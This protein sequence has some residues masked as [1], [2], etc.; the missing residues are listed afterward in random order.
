ME[1]NKQIFIQNVSNLRNNNK[2]AAQ[3]VQLS[4]ITKNKEH[5]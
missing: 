4:K 1:E 3:K 2:R 5:N